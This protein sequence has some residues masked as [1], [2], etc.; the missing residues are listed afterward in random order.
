MRLANP[1][2]DEQPLM[3][4]RLLATLVD[5]LR[6]NV[7]RGTRDVGLFEVGLVVD[8]DG[9]QRAAPTEDVGVRPSEETLTAIR[10][11]VPAQPRH[12]AFTLTGDRDRRGWW[13]P[14]RPADVSDA[15]DVV[16]L[17]MAVYMS[18]EQGRTLDFPPAGVDAFA[19]A[20][21]RGAWSPGA[22]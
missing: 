15:V 11:A 3:R 21:A 10:A 9:A 12:L 22:A 6:R 17:L 4:T 13:G 14:G 20:V 2:S 19:P 7:A 16:R 18:A 1:L 5:A 8:L